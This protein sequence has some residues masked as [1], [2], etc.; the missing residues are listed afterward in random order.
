MSAPLAP[1]HPEHLAVRLLDEQV[2][3]R[4]VDSYL[5][6]LRFRALELA[7]GEHLVDDE[8]RLEK[9]QRRI[10]DPDTVEHL[11]VELVRQ[12]EAGFVGNAVEY[13]AE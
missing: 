1:L 8:F 5:A 13:L 9:S 11:I 10:V 7:R 12:L 3:E 4:V 2:G 6:E